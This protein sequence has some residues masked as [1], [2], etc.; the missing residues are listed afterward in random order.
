MKEVVAIIRMNKMN[1]TKEALV[2]AG[3]PA[4]T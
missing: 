3:F 4:F 1:K 2:D